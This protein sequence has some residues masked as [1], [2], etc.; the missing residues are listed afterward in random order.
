MEAKELTIGSIAIMIT[1]I[2]NL[3]SAIL[4]FLNNSEL[5]FNN[6]ISLILPLVLISLC[7]YAMIKIHRLSKDNNGIKE[8]YKKLEQDYNNEIFSFNSSQYMIHRLKR[9]D[10]NDFKNKMSIV[11]T[12]K[13][14]KKDGCLDLVIE[15]KF[16]GYNDSKRDIWNMHIYSSKQSNLESKVD[17]FAQDGDNKQLKIFPKPLDGTGVI[18]WELPFT[19]A[20]SENNFINYS[21]KIDWYEYFGLDYSEQIAIDPKNYSKYTESVK[22]GFNNDSSADINLIYVYRYILN[23]LSK[24]DLFIMQKTD[25]QKWEVDLNEKQDCVYL[26][27]IQYNKKR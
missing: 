15:Y 10:F 7:I 6:I 3:I 18:L 20:I 17:G 16:A 5:L 23:P 27:K 22:V 8:K 13:D 2:L 11:Y 25:N 1:S 21:F 19:S 14:S 12:L 24:E 4:N 9:T 26:L